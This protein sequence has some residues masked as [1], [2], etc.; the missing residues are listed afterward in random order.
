MGCDEDVFQG[1]REKEPDDSVSLEE[2]ENM[3]VPKSEAVLFVP[4]AQMTNQEVT[5]KVQDFLKQLGHDG[6]VTTYD[7]G[8]V[9]RK[10][11]TIPNQQGIEWK[12]V[13]T[14]CTAELLKVSNLSMYIQSQIPSGIPDQHSIDKV[15]LVRSVNT[16]LIEY[17]ALKE[18]VLGLGFC[19]GTDGI[20][21]YSISHDRGLVFECRCP[22]G[23]HKQ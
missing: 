6:T 16:L 22:N 12:R 14:I 18:F 13:G 7:P 5:D 15:N 3:L 8:Q 9:D 21:G 23:D 10:L 11:E 2:A 19:V 20:I 17:Q 1:R 4:A